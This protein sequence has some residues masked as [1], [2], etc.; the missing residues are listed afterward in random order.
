M[1]FMRH[2]VHLYSI[3]AAEPSFS[4]S[5]QHQHIALLARYSRIYSQDHT[6]FAFVFLPLTSSASIFLLAFSRNRF[7]LPLCL[8][9]S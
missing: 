5:Q 1:S 2:F 9:C 6:V 7:V 3:Q 4:A 8:A